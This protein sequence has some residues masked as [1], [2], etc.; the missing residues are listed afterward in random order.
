MMMRNCPRSTTLFILRIFVLAKLALG[1]PSRTTSPEISV[2][3]RAISSP[4]G[5]IAR[6]FDPGN[7]ED[8]SVS[9]QRQL[10]RPI[11]PIFA[12]SWESAGIVWTRLP[13]L[14]NELPWLT[15]VKGIFLWSKLNL[16]RFDLK[17]LIC[18]RIH[19]HNVDKSK[20]HVDIKYLKIWNDLGMQEDT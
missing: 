5:L 15:A 1:S 2:E 19:L 3:H 8:C 9:W 14:T 4:F 12:E 13:L 7:C 6:A 20:R 10:V 16:Q 17:A 18:Q 11:F